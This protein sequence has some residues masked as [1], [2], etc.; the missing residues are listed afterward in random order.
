MRTLQSDRVLLDRVN[1]SIR[2]DRLAALEDG[3]DADLLPLNGDLQRAQQNTTGTSKSTYV[4]G[5]VDGLHRLANFRTN[6]CTSRHVMPSS[7]SK[8]CSPSPGISVTVYFPYKRQHLSTDPT[9]TRLA[10]IGTLL[11]SKRGRRCCGSIRA[12]DLSKSSVVL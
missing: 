1:S 11:S 9:A 10:Y 6:T 12:V 2:D 8:K 3:G 4:G 7:V 5:G